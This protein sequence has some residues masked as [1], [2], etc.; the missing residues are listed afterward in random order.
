MKPNI[1][2]ISDTHFGHENI[3]KYCDRPFK[4]AKEMDEVIIANWNSVV[5]RNDIV[6]HL[7]D[8]SFAE[9]TQYTKRLN[10]NIIL[11]LGNHDKQS[12]IAQKR[13]NSNKE[14]APFAEM[15]KILEIKIGETP[16]T[17]NHFAQRVWNKS[18]FNAY[19]LYGHSHGLLP[20]QGKSF[21]VGVDTNEFKPYSWEQVKAIM[22]IA[23]N[24][25]NFISKDN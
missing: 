6:Y 3:L 24:N 14:I 7:G 25:I 17:L 15:H 21:D 11:I 12:I 4:N 1:F 13:A 20:A 10:G 18:H 23:P 19:H 8:F 9:P 16:I 5:D 2:F 22:K